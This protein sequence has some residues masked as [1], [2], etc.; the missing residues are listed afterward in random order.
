MGSPRA[1]QAIPS[2]PREG[3]QAI[4]SPAPRSWRLSPA[5]AVVPWL[6]TQMWRTKSQSPAVKWVYRLEFTT[7]ITTPT[8]TLQTGVIDNSRETN[9]CRKASRLWKKIELRIDLGSAVSKHHIWSELMAQNVSKSPRT[10]KVLCRSRTEIVF[11][12][13]GCIYLRFELATP[14]F[15]SRDIKL[16]ED[17]SSLDH[18]KFLCPKLDSAADFWE[19]CC[20]RQTICRQSSN[21]SMWKDIQR[22]H[23]AAGCVKKTFSDNYLGTSFVQ[24]LFGSN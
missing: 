7:A 14:A 10:S 21:I 13:Q 8:S 20:E 1:H 11:N 6:Q 17:N 16:R 24:S 2:F 9:P 18:L 23:L 3:P 22:H 19:Y 4:P 12:H 15:T 5:G